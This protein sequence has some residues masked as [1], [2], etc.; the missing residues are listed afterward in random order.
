MRFLTFLKTIQFKNNFNNLNNKIN[1]EKAQKIKLKS[2]LKIHALGF[3]QNKSL[4]RSTKLFKQISNQIAKKF[5]IK[6]KI[7]DKE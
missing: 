2:I 3:F 1:L 4:K 7:M 5:L 6:E